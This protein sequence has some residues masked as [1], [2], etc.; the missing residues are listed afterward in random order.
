MYTAAL[1]CCMHIIMSHSAVVDT[2][3]EGRLADCVLLKPYR[4]AGQFAKF[5]ED[6]MCP[7]SYLC[8]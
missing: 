6:G 1:K 2:S 8:T 5:G 3:E 4:V 7:L